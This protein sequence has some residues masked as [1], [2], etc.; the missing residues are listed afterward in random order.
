MKSIISTKIGN[1]KI[2]SDNEF[3]ISVDITDEK[4]NGVSNFASEILR[5]YFCGKK[6]DFSE[7]HTCYFNK[8][9]FAIRVL[10]AMREI[11]YGETRSY[12]WLA[13]KAGN[14]KA[15]R[16]VSNIINKNPHMIISPCHRVVKS[17]GSLGGFAHG[18]DIKLKLL[19]FESNNSLKED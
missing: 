16:A 10:N 13:E 15:A 6:T 7:L 8:S 12:K 18:T 3:I 1:L 4:P 14:P 2:E 19:E 11:P 9:D 17:D 5:D